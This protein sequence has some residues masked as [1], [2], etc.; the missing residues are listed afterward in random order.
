MVYAVS[1]PRHDALQPVSRWTP[2]RKAS[3]MV[4]IFLGQITADQACDVHGLT[5]DELESWK[6]RH[7]RHGQVGLSV[8][9]LQ[10]LRL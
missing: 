3:V 10:E 6:V 8:L 4:A 9:K 5:V 1:G 2:A 7:R